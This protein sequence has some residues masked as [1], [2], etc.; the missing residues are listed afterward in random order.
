MTLK[1]RG[2]SWKDNRQADEIRSI[3]DEINRL[4]DKRVVVFENVTTAQKNAMVNPGFGRTVLDITLNKLCF[5][6]TDG[7]WHTVTSV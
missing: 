4:S 1:T 6:G 7:A 3:I 2:D 5:Y